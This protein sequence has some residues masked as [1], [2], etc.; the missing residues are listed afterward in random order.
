M[1]EE[2]LNEFVEGLIPKEVQEAESSEEDT[3]SSDEE[4]LENSLPEAQEEERESATEVTARYSEPRPMSSVPLANTGKTPAEQLI[5]DAEEKQRK[6]FEAYL[7]SPAM[8]KARAEEEAKQAR[9]IEVATASEIAK[10]RAEV[11]HKDSLRSATEKAKETKQLEKLVDKS[12]YFDDEHR[13]NCAIMNSYKEKYGKGPNAIRYAFKREYGPKNAP[14]AVK[15]EIHQVRVILNTQNLPSILKGAIV[16]IC[17]VL[18]Q[19]SIQINNPMINLSGLKDDSET[20]VESGL[21]DSELDQIAID[22]AEWFARGPEERFALKFGNMVFQNLSGNWNGRRS[23]AAKIPP[24]VL[25]RQQNL[26]R[27]L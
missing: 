5:A 15:Q 3:S 23:T 9:D 4:G 6:Q 20:C 22:W 7:N 8:Q 19:A 17:G 24:E 1:Q 10:R 25:Q 12:G 27:G 13:A 18:E 11:V 2:E 21:F 26:G 14:S 16:K